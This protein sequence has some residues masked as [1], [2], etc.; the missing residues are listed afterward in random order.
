MTQ[1]HPTHKHTADESLFV[2]VGGLWGKKSSASGCNHPPAVKGASNSD[3]YFDSD[4]WPLLHLYLPCF[5]TDVQLSYRKRQ[6][7]H[8]WLW[9]KRGNKTEKKK[10][11]SLTNL[12]TL[13]YFL[14]HYTW[15]YSTKIKKWKKEKNTI[16]PLYF[17]YLFRHHAGQYFCET[18]SPALLMPHMLAN[19][20]RGLKI[21][22]PGV[23]RQSGRQVQGGHSATLEWGGSLACTGTTNID[24]VYLGVLVYFHDV[25]DEI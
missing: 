17:I 1:V 5:Q 20:C 11:F 22:Q 25:D 2:W 15:K 19:V 9:S 7:T 23:S 4:W 6:N 21:A 16:S 13:L 24:T 12:R 14:P 8:V 10:L 3:A 18:C